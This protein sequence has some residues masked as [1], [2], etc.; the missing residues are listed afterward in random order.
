MSLTTSCMLA[1]E[2]RSV[3]WGTWV[4]PMTTEHAEPG[5]VMC[6]TR[7]VSVGWVSASR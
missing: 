5:G 6:T 7:I 4:G 1:L 2:P 3:P